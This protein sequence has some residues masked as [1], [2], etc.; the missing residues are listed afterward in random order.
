MVNKK[1]KENRVGNKKKKIFKKR[2]CNDTEH[3][4][5]KNSKKKYK[6]KR[7][8]KIFT[9]KCFEIFYNTNLCYESILYV[10]LT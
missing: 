1:C 9:N 4:G 8:K 5:Q 7:K 2:R 6:T 10:P 3:K